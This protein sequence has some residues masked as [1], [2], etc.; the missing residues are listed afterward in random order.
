MTTIRLLWFA[1][2][3]LAQLLTVAG[4]F[5]ILTSLS[6]AQAPLPVLMYQWRILSMTNQTPANAN[7][8]LTSMGAPSINDNSAVAFQATFSSGGMGVVAASPTLPQ[9]LITFADP[10]GGRIFGPT[11]HINDAN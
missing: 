3:A 2:N 9:S 5:P 6:M 11:V 8:P 7:A 1:T 4:L 10:T